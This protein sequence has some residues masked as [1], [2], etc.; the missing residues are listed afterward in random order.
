MNNPGID[1]EL[2]KGLRK[3]WSDLDARGHK[4]KVDFKLIADPK[5]TNKILMIDVIQ[6]VDGEPITETVQRSAGEAYEVL[7]IEGLSMER[8]VQV[9]KEM[10]KKLHDGS[11]QRQMDLV[12]T[13]SPTSPTSGE[14]RAILEKS[15]VSQ[16]STIVV[17]YR[18]YYV[19]NALREKMI[20]LLGE[21]WKQV[22]AIYHSATLDFYFEY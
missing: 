22:R 19:L 13:M 11:S 17:N 9:Y 12:V 7:G 2:W 15:D 18:H 5:D 21:S 6:H 10:L 16:K 8:L 20:E 4:V 3:K 14:V 1:M